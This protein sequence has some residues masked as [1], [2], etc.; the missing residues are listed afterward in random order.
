HCDDCHT[1]SS[2]ATARV[3][4]SGITANCS[5]CH[6]VTAKGKNPTHIASANTCEDCHNTNT[7]KP[8]SRVDHASVRGSCSTCHNNV[9][10]KGKYPGHLPTS[11]LCDDC[12]TTVTWASARMDHT[13]ITSPCTSCHIGSRGK[14]PTHITTS[15]QCDNCHTTLAWAPANFDHNFATGSCSNCHNG[16]TATGK[17]GNHFGT[18]VQCN[19][20]HRTRGWIPTLT[21]RHSSANFPGDH[22]AGVTC[23]DCHKGNTQQATW[24]TGQYKPDCAGCHANDYKQGP[25]KK[26]K[27]PTIF[28]TVGELRDCAGPCHEYTDSTFTTIRKNRNGEHRTNKGGF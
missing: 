19:E 1:T 7:F 12:H 26:T 6:G 24:T 23:R 27:N 28:Y 16:V 18:T 2:F 21:F 14:P 25:H 15:A 17:P 10:A 22:N 4:H 3:D 11:N 5:S 13:G 9:I 8:V 20:C